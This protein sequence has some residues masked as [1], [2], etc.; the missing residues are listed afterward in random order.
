M[1]EKQIIRN[2]NYY[3]YG[4]MALTV[5]AAVTFYLLVIKQILPTVDPQSL[6]GQ[7]AQY[8]TILDVLVTIPLGLWKHKRNCTKIAAIEDEPTRL[9]AYRKSAMWRII[10]VSNTMLFAFPLYYLLGGYMSMLWVAG[11]AAIGWYFTKPTE[12]KMYFE[13]HPQEEQY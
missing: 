1:N 2:L 6:P 4:I 7:I 13:L 9:E 10:F 3:Y 5:C 12:K 11:I 8:V